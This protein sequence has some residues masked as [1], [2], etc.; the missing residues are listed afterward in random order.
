MHER[1][2]KRYSI[3]K[4]QPVN[5]CEL[6]EGFMDGFMG[7]IVDGKGETGGIGIHRSLSLSP[8]SLSPSSL[9]WV[10]HFSE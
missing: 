4:Q 9:S 8:S 3:N 2:M 5:C 7:W 1:K 6:N 10:V